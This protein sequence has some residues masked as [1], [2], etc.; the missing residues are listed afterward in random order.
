MKLYQDPKTKQTQFLAD[1]DP[2]TQTWEEYVP[3]NQK[4]ETAWQGG[5]GNSINLQNKTSIGKSETP[6][7]LM[8]PQQP[9]LSAIPAT[10][11]EQQEEK[12][13]KQ[14]EPIPPPPPS[15]RQ[16]TL[17]Q[18][19]A[20]MKPGM[21]DVNAEMAAYQKN[22]QQPME[23][24]TADQQKAFQT[25]ETERSTWENAEGKRQKEFLEG[26]DIEQTLP[27]GE[28]QVYRVKGYNDLQRE[29][30]TQREEIKAQKVDPKKW[31][32]EKTT[33]QSVGVAIALALSGLGDAISRS[34][35]GQN[36]NYMQ[37]A[38]GLIDK[39]VERDIEAQKL[40]IQMLKESYSLSKEDVKDKM[41]I[42]LLRR[43]EAEKQRSR[44]Y[45]D[46]KFRLDE[47]ALKTKDVE[48]QA[49]AMEFKQAL[50]DKRNKSISDWNKSQQDYWTLKLSKE[51]MNLEEQKFG[52]EVAKEIGKTNAEGTKGQ[53]DVSASPLMKEVWKKVPEA[54]RKDAIDEVGIMESVKNTKQNITN[55]YDEQKKIGGVAGNL[56]FSETKAKADT[57]LSYIFS[58]VRSVA[59]DQISAQELETTIMPLVPKP[60]D[61]KAQVEAKKQQLMQF[62]SRVQKPTPILNN[63]GI[64]EAEKTETTTDFSKKW[65][66][67]RKGQ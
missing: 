43:T 50:E 47:I 38:L 52:L 32:N 66:K 40:N 42:E 48:T 62:I 20:P 28:T 31:Y 59:K 24:I 21:V 36:T 45:D 12:L 58:T 8:P 9:D 30:E 56:P 54:N 1:N 14:Q 44:I 19:P 49:K 35:G 55:F 22:I 39:A 51:K 6:G 53:L 16:D 61:T 18:P 60:T 57:A 65:G 34:Y 37:S 27:T 29:L 3:L 13:Q 5:G 64:K 25:F 63:F 11:L 67:Y 46:A 26:F 15:P 10:P 4:L 33:S 23:Q 7:T 41:Q 17:G 2:R